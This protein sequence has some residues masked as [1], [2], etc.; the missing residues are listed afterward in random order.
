MRFSS[1]GTLVAT[2]DDLPGQLAIGDVRTGE[3]R[4]HTV[5]QGNKT[6]VV[7]FALDGKTVATGIEK[8]VRVWDMATEKELTTL[9]AAED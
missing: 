3:R 1:D 4:A 2:I 8:T 9:P 6:R 7:A 5:A